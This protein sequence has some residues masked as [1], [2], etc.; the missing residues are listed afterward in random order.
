MKHPLM[1]FIVMF[2][3]EFAMRLLAKPGDKLWGRLSLNA[4]MW[5]RV[6]HIMKVGKNNFNPPPQVESN[7]VRLEI[8]NPRP[9]IS[10][11]EWDGLLRIAF[12]R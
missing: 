4:Q 8:K 7:V 2:Q 9:Q 12:N 11:E 5:A 1:V 3:R 10:Y 6:S